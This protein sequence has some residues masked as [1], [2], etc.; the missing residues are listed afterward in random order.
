MVQV[1]KS[2]SDEFFYEIQKDKIK[3]FWDNKEDEVWEKWSR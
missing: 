1:V 2:E 3:E